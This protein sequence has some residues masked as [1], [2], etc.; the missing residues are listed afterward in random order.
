VMMPMAMLAGAKADGWGRKALLL[1]GFAIL[2]IRGV[3]YT[4]SN[5]MAWL[6]G[7]QLLDG[8]GAGLFG[9][10]LP[11]IVHDLT[12]GT[13][14]FNV[15]QGA[16]S[17]AFGAGA[18]LS[19]SLAG[20]VVEA[21]GYSAAFLTLAAIAALAFGVLVLLMPET[22]PAKSRSTPLTAVPATPT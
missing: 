20:F 21:A 6:V 3:L 7:V 1:V 18:A 2:P 16:V 15:S 4:L 11:L 9:A 5:D 10:L 8:V 19:P 12:E 17:T 13:G 14:R 22:G